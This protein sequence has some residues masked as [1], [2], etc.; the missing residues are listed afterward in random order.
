[1]EQIA[2]TKLRIGTWNV[3]YASAARNPLRLALIER[4]DAD[5]WVLTETQDGLALGSS[6]TPQHSEPHPQKRPQRWVT[7]WS[8]HPLI[9]RIDVRDPIR[10]AAALYATPLGKVLVYGTVM[11]WSSDRGLSGVEA[12]WAE[13]HRVVSEQVKEC[14]ELRDD[15]GDAAICVAGDFNMTLG[16]GYPYGTPKGSQLLED[17][18]KEA[19]MACVTRME[20]VPRDAMSHIDHICVPEE[21]AVRT[22]VVDGWPGT[23]EGVRLSDHSAVV[24]ETRGAPNGR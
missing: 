6:Y 7:I 16:G 22:T 8:R 12:Y 5:I 4:A 10:T 11:P 18:L 13:H 1:M 3:E 19:G 23:I 20:H 2:Q 9:K 24:I 21:W 14:S 15:H 17:G